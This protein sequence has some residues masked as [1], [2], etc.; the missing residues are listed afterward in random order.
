MWRRTGALTFLRGAAL[1]ALLV[2][3]G[4]HCQ[5]NDLLGEGDLVRITV[6]QNPDLTTETRL[7]ERGVISFPLIGQIIL[8]GL[9]PAAAEAQI[10]KRLND[11]RFLI[12]PQVSLT[13]LQV[14]SRQ[15]SVLGQVGHPGRFPL[16]DVSRTLTDILAQAGGITSTGDETVF[17]VRNR[18]GKTSKTAVDVAGM[19]RTGDMSSNVELENGDVVYVERA[20]QF[21]ISGEVQKAGAYRVE[22][23][24]TV[25]QAVSVGGGLT[26]R[27][28]LHGIRILRKSPDGRTTEFRARL[29]DAVRA[30]DVIQ[31]RASLF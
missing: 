17:V 30:D 9:T 2:A 19:Y 27:G 11:G 5:P 7:A 18:D 12:H 22:P 3:A 31:I 16:D 14:R 1:A 24:M 4:A 15:V 13:V 21:Y 29:T 23:A 25:V 26:P 8:G 20:P 28:T 10:A 6:Y